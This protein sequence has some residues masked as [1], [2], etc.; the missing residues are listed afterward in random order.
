MSI[1]LNLKKGSAKISNNKDNDNTAPS[2]SLAS[3]PSNQK[4]TASQ[5]QM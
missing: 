3:H 4:S 1:N 2:N 5:Q